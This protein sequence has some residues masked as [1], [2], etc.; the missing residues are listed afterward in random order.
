MTVRPSSIS[1]LLSRQLLSARAFQNL[2]WHLIERT[3][4]ARLFPRVVS[5]A[6]DERARACAPV[7]SGVVP[8]LRSWP[9][10]PCGPVTSLNTLG[11][12]L[13]AALPPSIHI[14]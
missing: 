4:P 7:R 12:Q 1:R 11:S 6:S 9:N 13:Y 2:K 3:R 14:G 8:R 10:A 5:S